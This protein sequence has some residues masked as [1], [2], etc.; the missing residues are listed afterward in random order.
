MIVYP[1]IDIRNGR[2]V[3]LNQGRDD[4]QTSYYENPVEPAEQFTQAGA[5]WIHVVD[6][7]GAFG[8]APRNLNILQKISSLGPHVQ[9]GGGM[10]DAKLIDAALAAGASRVVIGT[11]AATDSQF[12]Q[13]IAKSH[14]KKLA[15]GIDAKDGL[16]AVKGWTDVTQLDATDFAVTVSQLGI[17]TVIYTDI[18]TD[19]MLTGPNWKSLEALLK[20]CTCGVIASGGVASAADVAKLAQLSKA[21]P[22]LVGVIVGKALYEGRTSVAELLE[23]SRT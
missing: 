19:G 21:Y 7:D 13:E 14:G 20:R 1:A 9:F 4:A 16:V 6:L 2:C 5:E 18:A 15:I 11:R 8:G 12:L 22:H 23:A 10:R 3:R 17:S